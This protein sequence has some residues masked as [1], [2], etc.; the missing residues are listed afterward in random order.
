MADGVDSV[1]VIAT[2][3]CGAPSPDPYDYHSTMDVDV[4]F[5][6]CDSSNFVTWNPYKFFRSGA[7]VQYEIYMSQTKVFANFNLVG[8]TNKPSFTHTGITAAGTY[9]YYV[10]ATDNQG[11]G[12][13]ASLSNLGEVLVQAADAPKYQYMHSVFVQSPTSLELLCYVDTST[14]T[15][16]YEVRRGALPVPALLNK[17]AEVDAAD[18]INGV[19]SYK[20]YNVN[21]DESSYY[22]TIN[23]LDSCGNLSISSNLGK[24]ILLTVQADNVSLVNKLQWLPYEE[25]LNGVD[26]YLIYRGV[27]NQFGI[28]PYDTVFVTAADG[29]IYNYVDEVKDY[30]GKKGQYCYYVVAVE[31]GVGVATI[32]NMPS[33]RA[34]SNAVCTYLEPIMY[35]PNA[36]T[37]GSTINPLFR[38]QGIYY[39]FTRYEMVIYNRWGETLFETT[40]Y[41][42]GWD[43][44]YQGDYVPVGSYVYTIRFMDSKNEER[45]KKGTVTVIR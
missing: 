37:P 4:E 41:L 36:F 7:Q 39:D 30:Q 42:D 32:A 2:D 26:R 9:Y 40:D 20:D 6:V 18:V 11:A 43:G 14:I 3:S 31:K 29:P 12:P 21:T 10:K 15:A 44:K 23:A 19:L 34:I 38:P 5:S 45:I 27:D 17:V 8:A 33:G 1:F 35:I 25:W 28:D 16:A 24:S 22:Y 13:F